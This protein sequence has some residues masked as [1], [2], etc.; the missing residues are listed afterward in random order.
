[1]LRDQ[2]SQSSRLVH[3]FLAHAE[4]QLETLAK[5]G[6]RNSATADEC[7]RLVDMM[8]LF[9]ESLLREQR[10]DVEE[11]RLEIREFCLKFSWNYEATN[12]SHPRLVG[13]MLI[14]DLSSIVSG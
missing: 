9:F 8:C 14:L 6:R 11:Y 4:R 5:E 2:A 10:I 3:D 1:M 7:S 13:S 12:V